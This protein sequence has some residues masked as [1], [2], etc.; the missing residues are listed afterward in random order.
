M[1]KTVQLLLIVI[2]IVGIV[3]NVFVFVTYSASKE[4]CKNTTNVFICSQIIID[5]IASLAM[6]TTISIRETGA[7]NCTVGIRRQ[8]LCWLFENFS[9]IGATMHASTSSLIVIALE[10][11][12]KIVHPVKHRNNFCPW[13]VKVGV[14]APWIDG[15]LLVI[16]PEWL[17]SDVVDGMCRFAL[18]EFQAGKPYFIF[19]FIWHDIVPLSIFLYCYGKILIVVRRQN[20]IFGEINQ[21][22][23]VTA[24]FSSGC[25]GKEVHATKEF[26]MTS[27]K[28][29]PS[30]YEESDHRQISSAERKIILTMLTLTVCYIICWFPLDLFLIF[31]G[32]LP[33]TVASMGSLLMAIPAYVNV[34]LNAVIYSFRLGVITRSWRALRRL[35][36]A[37]VKP[38][39]C[40]AQV[41]RNVQHHVL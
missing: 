1:M 39:L 24:G 36:S 25:S 5:A 21:S 40:D 12:F 19:I 37:V 4:F 26:C 29:G 27:A 20:L 18:G 30:A 13:M 35:G 7:T 8:I 34:V 23:N 22:N 9:F 15:L 17:M 2:C 28:G 11:Y 16:L 3:V 31:Y 41:S 14:I 33:K 32:F 6:A 10:R 38:E